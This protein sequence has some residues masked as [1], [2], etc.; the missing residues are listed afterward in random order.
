YSIGNEILELGSA[1][2]AIWSR[3]LAEAVRELDDTRF[4]TNGIN[5]IIANL[6]RMAEAQAEAA[7]TDPNTLMA[8][9]G[10]QMALMN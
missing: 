4:V 8:T 3:R 7:A 1:H 10:E 9:M 5:G 6:D 2:G